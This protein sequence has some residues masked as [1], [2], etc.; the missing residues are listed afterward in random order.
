MYG[1]VRLGGTIGFGL[2]APIAGRLVQ[3]HG[4]KLAF[5]G[6]AALLVLALIVSQKLVY[7]RSRVGPSPGKGGLR[8]LM[9]RRW[10]VFL[11]VAFAGGLS[12]AATNN[13]LFPYLKE[14]GAKETTMGIGLALGTIGEVPVLFFGNQLLK[15]FKPYGLLML[16]MAVSGVRLLLFAASGSPN[17]VLLLQ[18]FNGVTFPAMWVA[19]VSYADE[20]APAGM[21]ATAQ[22]L[23]S[24]TVFGFGMAM[25]GFLGG[26]LLAK[27]GGH[28][29]YLV[30]GVIVLAI[31]AIAW[32]AGR[33]LTEPQ[34]VP[35]DA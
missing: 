33:L 11:T 28:G 10:A 20:N 35:I 13:F 15:R 1:R 12:I 30:F 18:L 14:L 3:D 7:S 2:A 16:A 21:G 19:G 6:G 5:W 26:P 17:L 32:M 29:L 25:G 8:L 4:L 34:A 27:L 22:G 31:L 9:N 24:A 23:F